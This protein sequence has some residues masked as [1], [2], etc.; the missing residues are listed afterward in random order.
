MTILR[1]PPFSAALT[2]FLIVASLLFPA[3]PAQAADR[4]RVMSFLEVTGFDVALD[5]IALSASGAPQMLGLEAGDFGVG[6]ARM[7]DQVFDTE[8]MRDLALD[9]LVDTLEDTALAHAEAFYGSAL[10][11]R[12]VAAENASHMIEDDEVKQIA[13]QR[14]IADLVREGSDRIALLQRMNQ[15]IDA[16][17]TGVKAVQQIQFRFIMAAS[18]AGVIDLQLDAEGLRA[19]QRDQAPSMRMALNASAMAASAY[20]YQGFTDAEVDAYV[21]ALETPLMQ[22]VYELLNAVQYEITANRF[23]ELAFRMQDLGQGEEL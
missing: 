18:A 19:W 7:A 6:W 9:I 11:Q 2:A 23:E 20:T 5:S 15:A 14:I 21:R 12:L 10:G 13:G 22:Q 4:S 17:D 16:A 3:A 8:R 1:L